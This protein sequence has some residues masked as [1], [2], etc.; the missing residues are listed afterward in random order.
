MITRKL[1]KGEGKSMRKQGMRGR[2]HA[3]IERNWRMGERGVW[4]DS[5]NNGPK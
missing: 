3:M 1:R 2:R 4:I 5:C